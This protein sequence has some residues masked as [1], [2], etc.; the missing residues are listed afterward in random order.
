MTRRFS[1]LTGIAAVAAAAGLTLAASGQA[2]AQTN[3]PANQPPAATQSPPPATEEP[4]QSEHGAAMP[5][6]KMTHHATRR[7]MARA[8]GMS[9]ET[10]SGNAAVD[11][12][13]QESLSAAQ[14]GQPFNPGG[15]NPGGGSTGTMAP[16]PA[17]PAPAPNKGM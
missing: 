13:N 2:L 9:N 3:P 7:H 11:K 14:A 17:A 12:L 1:F 4:A 10:E 6:H 16:A 15:G 8:H 5:T